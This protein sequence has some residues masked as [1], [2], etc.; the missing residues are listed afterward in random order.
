[1]TRITRSRDGE[2]GISSARCCAGFEAAAAAG[3]R[4]VAVFVGVSEA[5]SKKSISVTVEERSAAS[6]LL[7]LRA[8][9][10]LLDMCF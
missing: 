8:P 2:C 9:Y 4:E 7:R 10:L 1:M 6:H 5:L 3:A